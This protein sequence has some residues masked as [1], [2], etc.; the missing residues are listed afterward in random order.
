MWNASDKATNVCRCC[1]RRT[2]RTWRHGRAVPG[3][4]RRPVC[5]GLMSANS[6]KCSLLAGLSAIASGGTL[7]SDATSPAPV[8]AIAPWSRHTSASCQR[9][10]GRRPRRARD[11]FP[12]GSTPCLR[13]SSGIVIFSLMEHRSEH[14]VDAVQ[15]NFELHTHWRDPVEDP[16]SIRLDVIK[17]PLEVK[18]AFWPRHPSARLWSP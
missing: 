5:P 7:A 13:S 3:R 12:A 4:E 15:V 8:Q 6:S 17:P 9:R 10:S 2:S 18:P 16:V 1:C 14:G 11:A